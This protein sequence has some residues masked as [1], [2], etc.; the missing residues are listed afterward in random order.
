MRLPHSFPSNRESNAS[1]AFSGFS[2]DDVQ[3]AKEFYGRT[4]GLELTEEY[5]MVGLHIGRAGRVLV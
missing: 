3:R 4:L 5:G 2:V 1:N